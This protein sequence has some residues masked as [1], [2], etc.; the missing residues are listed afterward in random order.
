MTRTRTAVLA[1]AVGTLS[2]IGISAAQPSAAAVAQD[3]PVWVK[4]GIYAY[5]DRCAY[6]KNQMARAGYQTQPYG[7][8]TCWGGGSQYF[9]QWLDHGD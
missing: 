6:A 4:S 3:P 8:A 5:E 9:F 7:D 1:A 2:A